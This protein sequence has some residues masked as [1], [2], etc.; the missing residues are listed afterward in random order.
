MATAARPRTRLMHAK[1]HLRFG[2]WNV[3]TVSPGSKTEQ[4]LRTMQDY[5]LDLLALLEVWWLDYGSNRLDRNA[6]IVQTRSEQ[7]HE[8]EVTLMMANQTSLALLQWTLI[9]SRILKAR[10]ISAHTK[11]TVVVCYAL[12]SE[13]FDQDEFNRALN[14]VP[15]D[16]PQHH[17]ACFL[18]E[19]NTKVIRG[20]T[21]RSLHKSLV[22][23]ELRQQNENGKLL[24]DFAPNNNLVIG[25]GP[26]LPTCMY[27]NTHG[28][29]TIALPEIRLATI[30]G[31][32]SGDPPYFI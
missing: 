8:Y 3:R 10:F 11:P 4:V 2:I 23:H 31:A 1:Q 30:S 6:I 9:S 26:Y 24:I 5:H 17:I 29:P 28:R 18:R 16:I 19:F 27:T 25:G 13:D 21:D 7:R 12:N 20:E 14:S 15:K 22:L 32:R